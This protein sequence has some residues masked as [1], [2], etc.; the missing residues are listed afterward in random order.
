VYPER[1]LPD[2][3]RFFEGVNL[4]SCQEEK[5]GVLL[6]SL[7]LLQ[8]VILLRMKSWRKEGQIVDELQEIE[9]AQQAELLLAVFA[10]WN[11]RA[12]LTLY[13]K[14]N[15]QFWVQ[16]L[17]VTVHSCE[18]EDGA[19]ASFILQTLQVILPKL[20]QSYNADVFTAL[21][22]AGLAKAL[23]QKV[24]FASTA[25]DKT[26]DFS[27]DRLSQLFRA[28]LSGIY[29]PI[30][31]PELR[32]YCY[33]I[34]FRYIHGT[35]EKATLNS[36]LGRHTLNTI[37]NAGSHLLEIICDDAYSGQDMCKV[38]AL[39][40]LNAFVA[41]ATRQQSKYILESF[42]S[43]NFVGVLVDNLKHIP[44]ELRAAAAP[45]V[46]SLLS[47]YD[48]SLALLLRVAQSRLGAAYVL[49]AGLFPAVRDS[50]IFAVD[51]DIGLEFDNPNALKKYYDLMLNVLRVI[52]AAVIARG[53]QNDQTVFQAR[54]FLKEN[55]HSM[56]AMFKRSVNVGGGEKAE[57]EQDLA[58]LVDCWTV[59]V[60]ITGFLQVSQAIPSLSVAFANEL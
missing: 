11:R 26:G 42:V 48:A 41:V 15:L 30:S 23:I 55:R 5:D 7:P 60:D 50:Q 8:Q 43:L 49:N 52:N 2:Q 22:L 10:D 6:Y 37:K 3:H 25:F 47:Y 46:S 34:C 36:P 40:L 59:L 20:E 35:F 21:Q 57:T 56:V 17:M 29:S 31:T 44:E 1:T 54:E 45:Q 32:E 9:L 27:N 4:A 33:Q 38:S 39:L 58:D 19:R 24:D 13:H 53:R 14:D 51:P 12:Q 16:V 28:A 18:F